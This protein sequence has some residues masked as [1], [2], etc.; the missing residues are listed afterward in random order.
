MIRNIK[1]E[2]KRLDR[3][4]FVSYSTHI[5]S[6]FLRNP[7]L[8]LAKEDVFKT[9]SNPSHNGGKLYDPPVGGTNW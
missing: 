2:A 5:L 7:S 9:G 8:A 1:E 3:K 6:G 4:E